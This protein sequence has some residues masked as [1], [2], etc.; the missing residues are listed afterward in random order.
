MKTVRKAG[1]ARSWVCIVI[2]TFLLPAGA[3]QLAKLV[4]SAVAHAGDEASVDYSSS[5]VA[6]D[7]AA[8]DCAY[9]VAEHSF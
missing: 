6:H 9:S 2:L 8:S 5:L 7:Q 3:P 1:T 4:F